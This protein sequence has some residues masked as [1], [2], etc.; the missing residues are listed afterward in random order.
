MG[1][2]LD[3][4]SQEWVGETVRS[5]QG[6]AVFKMLQEHF[7]W[8]TFATLTT[9][10]VAS[11]ERM[12]KIIHRTYNGHRPLKGCDYFYVLEEFKNRGG[13]HAHVLSKNEPEGHLWTK[14]WAWYKPKFGV[15]QSKGLRD[16]DIFKVAAY[17]TKYCTKDLGPGTWGF[18]DSLKVSTQSDFFQDSTSLIPKGSG[19]REESNKILYRKVFDSEYGIGDKRKMWNNKK[20][21]KLPLTW[22]EQC[23]KHGEVN[24]WG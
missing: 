17:V 4:L 18:S 16:S 8:S 1:S 5:Q 23:A 11:A 12:K 21:K 15:F 6:Q 24:H 10:K 9:A 14:T 13:V 7:P 20:P 22:D 2:V 3:R 19:V